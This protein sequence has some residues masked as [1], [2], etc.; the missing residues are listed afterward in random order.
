MENVSEHVT[1]LLIFRV[2][3]LLIFIYQ[4][5]FLTYHSQLNLFQRKYRVCT[6]QMK[7]DTNREIVGETEIKDSA[8]KILNSRRDDYQKQITEELSQFWDQEI[9][10]QFSVWENVARKAKESIE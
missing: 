6:M 2:D 10:N 4:C 8:K 5:F 7:L 3:S 1:N 9:L